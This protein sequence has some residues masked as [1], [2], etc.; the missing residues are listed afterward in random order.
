MICKICDGAP[1]AKLFKMNKNKKIKRFESKRGQNEK[2]WKN[3][4]N[5]YIYISILFI[6]LFFAIGKTY[7]LYYSFLA[8]PLTL[9]F[10]DDLYNLRRCSYNILNR[11][12][13]R[14]NEKDLPECWV[15]GRWSVMDQFALVPKGFYN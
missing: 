1:I 8:G 9:H 2:N 13:W 10:Q 14:R 7:F 11:W 15:I 5:I 6:Y 12:K 3:I 4:K